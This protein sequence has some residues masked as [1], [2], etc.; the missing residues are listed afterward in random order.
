MIKT[1][2]K[3]FLWIIGFA[4]VLILLLAFSL[5]FIVNAKLEDVINYDEPGRLYNYTFS[6]VNLNIL[7]GDIEINDVRITPIKKVLDSLDL[8]G[9]HKRVVFEG[10][11]NSI[12]II[13]LDV[14]SLL[15]NQKV[16]IDSFLIINPAINIHINTKIKEEYD[17]EFTKD[18][19][20]NSIRYGEIKHVG[21]ENAKLKWVGKNNDSTLYFSCDSV[22]TVIK[23]LHTVSNDN[24]IALVVFNDLIFHGKK[25]HINTIKGFS[26]TA[27]EIDYSL[28]KD[29][30]VLKSVAFKNI[31]DKK[32]FTKKQTHEKEWYD[33]SVKS[34][35]LSKA[36]TIHWSKS[37]ELTIDKMTIEKPSVLVYKDKRLD[38]PAFV[39][40]KLPT[41]NIRQIPFPILIDTIEVVKGTL[42]YQ[43]IVENGKVPGE[44]FF[45]HFNAQAYNITNIDALLKKKDVL[46]LNIKTDFLGSAPIEAHFTFNITDSTDQFHAYGH[47]K[48][49]EAS[50]L[51]NTLSNMAFIE[52]KTGFV[53]YLK[54]DFNAD[55]ELAEGTLDAHY[56]DLRV[57]LL[58]TSILFNQHKRK[59]K[60]AAGWLANNLLLNQNNIPNTKKYV[61]GQI[62]AERPKNKAITNYFWT[63]IKSGLIT[64]A[65]DPR[66]YTIMKVKK[67]LKKK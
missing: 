12:K 53:D 7:H 19:I 62:Y 1:A 40:K 27:Q 51:N 3:Y 61:Q 26:L 44:V 28:R 34:I 56:R 45:T 60:V 11:L 58:D 48:N 50:K 16:I 67:S 38:D 46:T 47:I 41:H 21:L 57:T 39:E 25:F 63:A 64:T 30:V 20:S 31:L 59:S 14:I 4:T 43:E 42:R 36:N 10:S 18:I 37:G 2:L 24:K 54:F 15:F 32:A 13:N 52:F 66:V 65:I 23:N 22:S 33:V 9:E 5:N 6:T 29:L 17:Q 35:S 55:N 8:I 49:M